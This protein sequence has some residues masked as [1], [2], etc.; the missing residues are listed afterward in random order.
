[1]P[2]KKDTRD[3][4]A[5]NARRKELYNRPEYKAKITQ[6]HKEYRETH[7]IDDERRERIKITNSQPKHRYDLL[8][9]FCKKNNRE[10]TITLEQYEKICDLPCV[11]CDDKMCAIKVRRGCGLDRIDNNRGY[12]IDNVNPCCGI[13]NCMRGNYLTVEEMKFVIINL[14]K[15]RTENNIQPNPSFRHKASQ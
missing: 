2:N 3:R 13:C 14:L 4:T 12:H 6:K 10:L 15:Y 7:P 9:R 1:M 11:Y 8:S 5:Y